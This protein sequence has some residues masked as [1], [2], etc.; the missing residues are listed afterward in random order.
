VARGIASFIAALTL[1]AVM[2]LITGCGSSS[3]SPKPS[4]TDSLSAT[5]NR[6]RQL[7][8]PFVQCL[9]QHDIPI[10]DK[11]Q[12]DMNVASLGRKE[13]WYKNGHV[14][15]NEAFDRYFQDIEGTYPI[16]SDFKPDQTIASW[17]DNA[18]STGRWPK[19]CGAIPASS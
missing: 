6:V 2:L 9:A 8:E 17:I 18:A 19:V 3:T 4:A 13:G 7:T 15:H 12:G 16:G 1:L 11:S 5:L 10:W 14:L